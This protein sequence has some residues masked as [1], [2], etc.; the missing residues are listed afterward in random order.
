MLYFEP[1]FL[2]M[3]MTDLLAPVCCLHLRVSFGENGSMVETLI[4][5]SSTMPAEEKHFYQDNILRENP[6]IT[7]LKDE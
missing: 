5:D 2:I 3:L 7:R 4:I 6:T 1:I